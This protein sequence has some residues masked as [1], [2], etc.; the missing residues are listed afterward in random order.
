MTNEFESFIDLLHR[1]GVDPGADVVLGSEIETLLDDRGRTDESTSDGELLTG[2]DESRHARERDFGDITQHEDT[3][4]LQHLEVLVPTLVDNLGGENVGEGVVVRLHLL[5]L[6][7]ENVVITTELL[8]IIDLVRDDIES[9]NF[10]THGLGPL[11]TKVTE[12]TETENGNLGALTD[13]VTL[14]RSV[15]CD[16]TTEEGSSNFRREVHGDVDNKVLVTSPLLG[17]TTIGLVLGSV[18]I[19]IVEG[20]DGVS[21]TQ[22]LHTL[23]T[24]ITLATRSRLTANTTTIADLD[25]LDVLTDLGDVTDDF[26]T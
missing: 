26:V 13:T 6:L 25:A 24:E 23:L 5:L 8:G 7:H 2:H 4:V 19:A 10:S 11:D 12:T 22:V 15:C 20:P 3:V 9:N 14:E 17:E 16:T 1:E 21:G 18:V